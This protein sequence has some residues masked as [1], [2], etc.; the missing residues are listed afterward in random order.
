MSQTVILSC[1][2]Q[3]RLESG[4]NAGVELSFDCLGKTKAR[5]ATR[6]RFAVWSV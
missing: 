5:N 1:T 4:D 3:D 2:G 6:H